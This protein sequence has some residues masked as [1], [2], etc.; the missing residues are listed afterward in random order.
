MIFMVVHK[1]A[2]IILKDRKFLAV[3]TSDDG[4]LITPGGRV[5]KNETPEETLRRELKEELNVKL[6]SMK[7]FGTFKDKVY[8]NNDDLILETYFADISGVPKPGSEVEK[9]F[10]IDSRFNDNEIKL[11]SAIEKYIIPKLLDTDLIE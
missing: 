1:I 7:F 10:W 3:K 8:Q 6:I 11:S 9:F 5:E 4:V 2:G